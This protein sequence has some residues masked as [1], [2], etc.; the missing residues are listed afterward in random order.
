MLS[1][2]FNIYRMTQNFYLQS[3]YIPIY[4]SS[5]EW[6]CWNP[7]FDQVVRIS[8]YW[9]SI[10]DEERGIRE[11]ILGVKS[12]EVCTLGQSFWFSK[13]VFKCLRSNCWN[14]MIIPGFNAL[15]YLSN[16]FW[17]CNE[18]NFGQFFLSAQCATMVTWLPSASLSKL[19]F[20]AADAAE[21]NSWICVQDAAKAKA[22]F[23]L[24]LRLYL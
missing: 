10:L 23:I 24:N 1:N 19:A 16:E 13:V 9:G 4:L 15:R 20:H 3:V 21:V 12:Q 17:I 8:K 22:N 6:N 7:H 11:S 18:M 14:F 5:R 2:D